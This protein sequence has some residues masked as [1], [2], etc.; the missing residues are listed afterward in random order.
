MRRRPVAWMLILAALALLSGG[1]AS[2]ASPLRHSGAVVRIDPLEGVLVIEE[3]GFWWVD[4]GETVVTRRTI[5]LRPTTRFRVFIR[6]NVPD[7]YGGDFL[8]VALEATDIAPG[9]FV[10]AECVRE[11]GRLVALTVTKAEMVVPPGQSL[12]P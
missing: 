8:E 3:V 10:T 4:R 5:G 11:R 2:A 6:I 9:D 1:T 12:G 7:R